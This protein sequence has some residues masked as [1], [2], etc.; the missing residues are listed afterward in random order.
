MRNLI[1]GLSLLFLTVKWVSIFDTNIIPID[2]DDFVPLQITSSIILSILFF[3]LFRKSEIH[4]LSQMKGEPVS[5]DHYTAP[6]VETKTIYFILITFFGSY[7]PLL[8]VNSLS[9]EI[10]EET[11]KYDIERKKFHKKDSIED[12]IEYDVKIGILGIKF[13]ETN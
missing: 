3:L 13:I 9:N 4:I 5:N 8:M 2:R 6:I 10:T 7:P 1:I 12:G 11:L